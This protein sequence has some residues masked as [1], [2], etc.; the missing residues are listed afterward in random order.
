MH[1]LTT[2]LWF[3]RTAIVLLMAGMLAGC[4]TTRNWLQGR[5]THEAEPTILGAPESSQYIAEL[6]ALV[7][8]DPAT[9]AEIYADAKAAS[10]LTPGPTNRLRFALVLAAPGHAGSDPLAA[11]SIFRELL[12]QTELLT[13]TEISLATIHLRE[14]EQRLVLSTEARRQRAEN[15]R[16]ASTEE[17]AIRQRMARIEAE[18]RQ[19]RRALSDAEGKLHAI[20]SIERA[21]REPATED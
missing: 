16:A 3:K 15:S 9:Q 19:L 11:Q 13:P 17:A 4:E 14:V 7:N 1:N 6:Y 10:E 21:V 20:T 5:Q 12:A 2:T 8:G 18:N